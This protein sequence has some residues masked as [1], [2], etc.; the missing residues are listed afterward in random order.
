MHEIEK[1]KSVR[2]KRMQ[3]KKQDEEREFRERWMQAMT[4][5]GARQQPQ[6][7]MPMGPNQGMAPSDLMQPPMPPTADQSGNP[8]ASRGAA[9]Y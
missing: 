1:R 8:Y 2:R 5:G 3:R 7:Q 6:Y 9:R 4:N